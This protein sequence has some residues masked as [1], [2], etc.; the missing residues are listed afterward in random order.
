MPAEH[1][2]PVAQWKRVVLSIKHRFSTRQADASVARIQ[3]RKAML[4]FFARRLTRLRC[5]LSLYILSTPSS[6]H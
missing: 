6:R 1:G 3:R 2:L 4:L 5:L